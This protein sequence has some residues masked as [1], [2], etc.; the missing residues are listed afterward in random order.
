MVSSVLMVCLGN[1]CRSPIAE[2]VMRAKV[3]EAGLSIQVASAGTGD[4][5]IGDPADYRAATVLDQ[6]GYTSQHRAQQ[7]QSRWLDEYDL[8]MVMDK[9]N[10]RGVLALASNAQ[11]ERKVK[12]LRSFDSTAPKDAEVPDPYYGTEKDFVAVLQMV[13]RACDGFIAQQLEQTEE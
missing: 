9:N 1:I 5:H 6:F 4:W 7:F 10:Q 2:H 3:V 11:H 8:I 12:L 13:E